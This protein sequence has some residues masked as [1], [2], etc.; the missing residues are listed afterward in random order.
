M[1]IH[2]GQGTILQFGASAVAQVLEVDGPE[3][4][5]ET[6]S[7]VNLASTAK[8][9]RPLLPDGGTLS[10]TIQYD[11]ADATHAALTTAI[12]TYPQVAS[13][14]SVIFSAASSPA[15]SFS[16]YLTKFKPTGMNEED[17]LQAEIELTI[18]GLVTWPT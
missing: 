7:T 15:A 5:V 6:T 17:N 1:A 2:A 4:S 10:A 9:K 3:A 14:C 18:T 8:T 13:A 12:N 16:A 11:P